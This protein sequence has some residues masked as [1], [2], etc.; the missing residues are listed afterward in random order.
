MNVDRL[1]KWLEESEVGD[2]ITY[3]QA[4]WAGRRPELRDLMMAAAEEGKVVLTQKKITEGVYNFMATRCTPK[5]G[6]KLKPMDWR[7]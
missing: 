2:R 6:K 4:D 5:T 7:V 1:K 3:M